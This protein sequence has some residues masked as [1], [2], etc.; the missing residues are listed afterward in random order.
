MTVWL[1]TDRHRFTRRTV[2]IGL[3]HAGYH[4]IIEG[5]RPGEQVVTEGAIFL[6]NLAGGGDS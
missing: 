2:K 3:Q 6:D 1:T 4:Q 5:V